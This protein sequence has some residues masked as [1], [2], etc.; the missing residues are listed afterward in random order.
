MK[1]QAKILV[2]MATIV[3][4]GSFALATAH[5][6]EYL[7]K[8]CGNTCIDQMD[9]YKPESPLSLAEQFVVQ[10]YTRSNKVEDD[11]IFRSALNK[12]PDTKIRGFRGGSATW[13]N[14]KEV[15]QVVKVKY[16]TG[17]SA[18]KEI[19]I[20]FVKDQLLVIKAVTAKDISGYS[21]LNEKELIL[22]PGTVLRVDK[23]A[24]TKVNFYTDG[25]NDIREVRLIE[26]T[27]L[28][29]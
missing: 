26:L 14:I 13:L 5:E 9:Y 19:A 15:G 3:G 17:I 11:I 24:T 21:A 1:L 10:A 4:L 29:Q 25:K 20:N 18:D 2:L 16:F 22:R 6:E 12:I 8:R 28:P 7:K 27:E 23:I